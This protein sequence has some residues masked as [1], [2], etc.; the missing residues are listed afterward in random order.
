MK[1]LNVRSKKITIEIY[2]TSNIEAESMFE[3]LT[4]IFPN[5]F[6]LRSI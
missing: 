2:F 3:G 6:S 1:S 5:L 4:N